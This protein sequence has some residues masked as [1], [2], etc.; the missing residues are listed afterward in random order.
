MTREVLE[1]SQKERDRLVILKQV[2]QGLISQVAAA[3]LLG[4]SDRHIRNLLKCLESKGDSGIVSKRRGKP[5]NH[6]ISESFKQKTLNLVNE[7]LEGFGPTLAA[8]KLEE[9][10]SLKVCSETLRLWM[11]EADL[12]TPRKKAKKVHKPRARRPCFGEL[13]QADGSHHRWF[14]PEHRMVNLTVMIDDATGKLTA[15]HFSEEETLVAYF[16]AMKQHL[17]HYGRPRAI[18]T[19]RSAIAEVRQRDSDTQFHKALKKLD[20]ELILANSPQAKGRVERVNRTLQDRLLR[21]LSLRGINNI[22]E[23][24]KYLPEFIE[25]F[26][27]QFGKI[28]MSTVDAHRSVKEYDLSVVLSKHE[29]RTL[30]SSCIFQYRNNFYEVQ[31]LAKERKNTGRKVDLCVASDGSFRVFINGVE[32]KILPCTAL[33]KPARPEIKTRKQVNTWKPRGS[34][35]SQGHP[36]RR[37]DPRVTR[38]QKVSRRV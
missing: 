24:N 11:I 32:R 8:E 30:I 5:G 36:W 19:D 16:T 15:L 27:E 6:R 1:M 34:V 35:P 26:N 14:G 7:R 23:A 2:Q 25:R 31:D 3:R 4:I 37:W 21:E 38:H 28:P 12:W 22:E 10:W 20:I 18:Y 29:E 9:L 33:E 13:I 17:T